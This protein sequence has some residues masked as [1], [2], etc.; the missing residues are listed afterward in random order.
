MTRML[1]VSAD[2]GPCPEL[3]RVFESL[4]HLTSSDLISL[5]L[6][7]SVLSALWSYSRPRRV[8]SWTEKRPGSPWLRPIVAHPVQM[9]YDQ[10][11]WGEMRWAICIRSLRDLVTARCTIVQLVRSWD[12]MSS[13]CPSVPLSV[14]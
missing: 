7:S 4:S 2:G 11:R 6:I 10:L 8:R 14:C 12:R 1:F 5:D 9:K 3:K 13:V